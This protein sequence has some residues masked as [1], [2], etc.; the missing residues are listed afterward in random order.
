MQNVK[1]IYIIEKNNSRSIYGTISQMK[2]MTKPQIKILI[3][4]IGIYNESVIQFLK[5]YKIG[6]LYIIHKV[7]TE[8]D[9]TGSRKVYDFKKIS[10][11]FLD[12]LN[13]E[14]S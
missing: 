3:R 5:D 8:K 13:N 12:K 7:T 9:H 14:W 6:K 4:V 1:K 2:D 11:K 10:E